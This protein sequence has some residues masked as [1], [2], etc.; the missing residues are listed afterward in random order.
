MKIICYAFTISIGLF[1]ER[2][3]RYIECILYVPVSVFI[4]N[5]TF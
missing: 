5:W 3:Y 2:A 4:L 1:S